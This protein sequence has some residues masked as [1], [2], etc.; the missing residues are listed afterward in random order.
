MKSL[1]FENIITLVLCI[2]CKTKGDVSF[3]TFV[4]S[5][6]P[7]ASFP[8][9]KSTSALAEREETTETNPH[10]VQPEVQTTQ[11]SGLSPELPRI[12]LSPISHHPESSTLPQLP[13]NS[14]AEV[15]DA[16]KE[17]ND[18]FTD[19][20]QLSN[21]SEGTIAPEV[22]NS[23]PDLST[24]TP[25]PSVT[26]SQ[27]TPYEEIEADVLLE[28]TSEELGGK[29]RRLGLEP[30]KIG[31]ISV[32]VFLAIEAVVLA[33]YCLLCRRRRRVVIVKSCEKDSEAGETINVESNDNTVVEGTVS[34][35]PC[36]NAGDS[37]RPSENQ[38]AYQQRGDMPGR[39]SDNKSTT[40]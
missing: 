37:S 24:T 33:V 10:M 2:V 35:S 8:V 3:Q 6:S 29:Q 38:E 1:G 39:M 26:E 11:H 28:E 18:I 13:E 12:N 9:L 31:V 36:Q 34:G 25:D 32:G 17:S 20:D 5:P 15:S 16:S 40:V 7:S 23:V 22:E 14:H 19:D 27:V 21:L 30:W 4:L